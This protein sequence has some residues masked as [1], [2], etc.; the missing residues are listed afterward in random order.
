MRHL[1]S[2]VRFGRAGHLLQP[3]ASEVF[4]DLSQCAPLQI[5]E[6]ESGRQAC[7]QAAALGGQ[8]RILQQQLL[9]DK[10]R[11]NGWKTFQMVGVAHVARLTQ[12][13]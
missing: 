1:E 5:G 6:P 8:L 13:T 4:S 7:T 10:A 2:C 12:R 11:H 9:I 3:S